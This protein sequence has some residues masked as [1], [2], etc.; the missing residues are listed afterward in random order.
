MVPERQHIRILFQCAVKHVG[1]TDFLEATEINLDVLKQAGIV[2]GLTLRAKVILSG[3]IS[4]KVTLNG[5]VVA[6]KGAKAAVEAVGGTVVAAEEKPVLDKLP[7][8]TK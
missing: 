3:K 1:R 2:S 6:T 8:K 7:A 4:R 5:G